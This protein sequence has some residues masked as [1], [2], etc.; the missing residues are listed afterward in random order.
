MQ[1][2]ITLISCLILYVKCKGLKEEFTWTRITYDISGISN[3]ST[4][5]NTDAA[6]ITF[7]GLV[8]S[9]VP[10]NKKG[11]KPSSPPTNSNSSSSSSSSS[12]PQ[13]EYV[14]GKQILN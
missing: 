7:P 5:V 6:Y 10:S 11:Y 14:Y 2:L 13:P 3:T 4:S 9:Y 1:L 12:Q 8:N